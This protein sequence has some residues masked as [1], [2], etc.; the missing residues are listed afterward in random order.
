MFPGKFL[1]K[2]FE[3]FYHMGSSLK[4]SMREIHSN[5]SFNCEKEQEK[6]R[7]AEERGYGR[8]AVE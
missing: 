3:T 5:E 8:G 2:F 7:R 6:S 1:M 4:R